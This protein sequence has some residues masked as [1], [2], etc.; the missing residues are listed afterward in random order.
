M[1]LDL[2]PSLEKL[3]QQVIGAS[4]NVHRA[5]GPGYLES[6]YQ[7]AL[8]VELSERNIQHVCEHPVRVH[9]KGHDVGEGRVDIL[10]EKQIVLELKAVDALHPIHQAQVL[11]YL[12]STQLQLGLL[13]NFNATAMKDGLK[14][15]ILTR[16]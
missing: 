10:V 4:I 2:H 16:P 12:K 9:Y 14:R 3:A 15:V 7:R 1:L 6:I 13:I 5:L 11:S 8:S